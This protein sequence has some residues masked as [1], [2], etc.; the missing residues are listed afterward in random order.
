MSDGTGFLFDGLFLSSSKPKP[1][2]KGLLLDNKYFLPLVEG[3]GSG[4]YYRC[5]SVDTSAKTWTGYRAVLNEGVYTFENT[6]TSGLSYTSVTP[7]VGNIYNAGCLVHVSSL[8]GAIPTDGLVFY[9]PLAEE[10]ATA[11]TGQT[12]T[13]TGTITYSTEDG[14][15]CATIGEDSRIGFPVDSFPVG[16]SERTICFWA[17]D[18]SASGNTGLKWS[19]FF[20]YGDIGSDEND[21]LRY[22]YVAESYGKKIGIDL[23]YDEL[24]GTNDWDYSKFTFFSI[25]YSDSSLKIYLDNTL[26][27]ERNNLVLKTKIS[28]TKLGEIGSTGDWT[29]SN[30]FNIAAVRVYNRALDKYELESVYNEFSPTLVNT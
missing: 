11:E 21:S 29:F 16:S 9:A 3:G 30:E 28:E 12:L 2:Q 6:V 14:I 27:A 8:Y 19:R 25:V 1:G 17:K 5:A 23:F 7:V 24:I 4:E 20:G 18:T 13:K 26:Y 22:L 10:K 15:P